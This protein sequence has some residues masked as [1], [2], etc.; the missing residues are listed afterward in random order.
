MNEV[1]QNNDSPNLP[2]EHWTEAMANA[3]EFERRQKEI[4][5]D[6]DVDVVESFTK[7]LPQI[8]DG[9][10]NY[11]FCG[12]VAMDLLPRIQ[13]MEV[14]RQEGSDGDPEAQGV[15]EF[16]EE[17]RAE[18]LKGVRKRGHDFDVVRVGRKTGKVIS[19][20]QLIEGC[21]NEESLD[22]LSSEETGESIMLDSVGESQ[23]QKDF[24][25]ARATLDD[26][27]EIYVPSPGAL[28]GLKA[29]EVANYRAMSPAYAG[30]ALKRVYNL[31]APEKV[32]QFNQ[33]AEQKFEEG[34]ARR[35]KDLAMMVAGFS[36]I[37]SKEEIMESAREAAMPRIEEDAS[38]DVVDGG[39]PLEVG[40]SRF[41]AE[42]ERCFEEA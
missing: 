9:K 42:I 26:G 5:A 37:M 16:S 1:E 2:G 10:V 28:I 3:P 19:K 35:E 32:E 17:A 7:I 39:V 31:D 38:Y 6:A 22:L 27:A 13:K 21:R 29:F 18:F 20:Q 11:Y 25:Y 4:I 24:S 15:V 36:K 23:S 40:I 34:I 12:S 30:E 33:K 14:F 8:E 41:E